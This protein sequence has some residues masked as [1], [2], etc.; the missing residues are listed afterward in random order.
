MKVSDAVSAAIKKSKA[1]YGDEDRYNVLEVGYYSL[2]DIIKAHRGCH[3]T[4]DVMLRIHKDVEV[5]LECMEAN[6]VQ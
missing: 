4:L 3:E 5:A 2:H 6:G 1:L